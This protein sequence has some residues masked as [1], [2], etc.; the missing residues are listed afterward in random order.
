VRDLAQSMVA[1]ASLL[2]IIILESFEWKSL[3]WVLSPPH[4]LWSESTCCKW[5]LLMNIQVNCEIV[6]LLHCPDNA[7]SLVQSNSASIP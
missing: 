5:M 7:L 3:D 6:L 4:W 2:L 1:V